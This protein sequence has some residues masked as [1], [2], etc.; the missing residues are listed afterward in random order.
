MDHL[1][2]SGFTGTLVKI[3][4]LLSPFVV[5]QERPFNSEKKKKNN[6]IDVDSVASTE[7]YFVALQRVSAKGS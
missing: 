7:I 1:T 2:C 3:A 6:N 4:P 5:T